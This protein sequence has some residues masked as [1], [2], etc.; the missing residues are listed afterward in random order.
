MALPLDL[1]LC[2]GQLLP[3]L[4]FGFGLGL[5]LGL[6][7]GYEG[8]GE[9]GAVGATLR[10]SASSM[11]GKGLRNGAAG[12]QEVAGE[13]VDFVSLVRGACSDRE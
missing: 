11:G 5:G 6:T 13:G 10:A 3:R 12:S 8:G 4:A 7:S 1:P 9:V 2:R